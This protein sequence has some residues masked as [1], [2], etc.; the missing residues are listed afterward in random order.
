MTNDECL[1]LI[2][3]LIVGIDQ[4]ISQQLSKIIQ[5]KNFRELEALWRSLFV[6]VNTE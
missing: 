4:K 3:N 1:S 5:H 6:L 2:S